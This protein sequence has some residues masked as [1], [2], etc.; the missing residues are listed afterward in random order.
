MI[1]IVFQYHTIYSVSEN[2]YQDKICHI[3]DTGIRHIIQVC[4]TTSLWIQ[5]GN[6]PIEAEKKHAHGFITRARAFY[7]ILSDQKQPA[8]RFG[9]M[10][11]RALS[12]RNT[13]AAVHIA[14]DRQ[15]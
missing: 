7:Q 4:L 15:T 14:K 3:S 10:K 5:T 13:P 6:E 8:Q 11:K 1:F 9:I 2:N 12:N